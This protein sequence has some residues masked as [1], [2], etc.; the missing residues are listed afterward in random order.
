MKRKARKRSGKAADVLLNKWGL[1]PQQEKFCR[2]YAGNTEFYGNGVQSYLEC[3]SIDK[4]K[5]NWYK[6]ACVCASQLLSNPRVFNRIN[7]LLSEQGLNDQFVDKQ[8]LF[9]ITQ[10][11]DKKAKLGG[12]K[13]YNRVKKRIEDKPG[14]IVNVDLAQLFDA[15]NSTKGD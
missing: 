11:E 10:H 9:L 15:A 7:D 1:N 12:I 2:L 4:K 8:T 5:P 3:F 13:E 6:T 14:V